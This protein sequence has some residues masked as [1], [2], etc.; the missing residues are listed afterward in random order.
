MKCDK[1][2]AYQKAK[3]SFEESYKTAQT[4]TGKAHFFHLFWVA[5]TIIFGDKKDSDENKP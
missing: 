1:E 2:K 3:K 5:V 4:Q